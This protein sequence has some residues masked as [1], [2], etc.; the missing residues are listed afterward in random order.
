MRGPLLLAIVVLPLLGV[1]AG[2]EGPSAPRGAPA[3]TSSSSTTP[4]KRATDQTGSDCP[5][6]KAV[7]E[8]RSLRRPPAQTGDVDGDGAVDDVSIALD[9]GGT[10]GCQAFL[11]VEASSTTYV[12]AIVGLDSFASTPD[13]PQIH[14]LVGIDQS[15]G[16]EIVVNVARGAATDIVGV[17]AVDDGR[18]TRVTAPGLA[19]GGSTANLFGYGGSVGHQDA[20]DCAGDAVVVSSAVFR[21]VNSY[22]LTRRFLDPEGSVWRL[23]RSRTKRRVVSPATLPR[24]APEFS[25]SPFLSC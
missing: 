18:L 25:S 4:T 8:D 13:L 22:R 10:V 3:A 11:V 1:I 15:R 19:P 5:D 16:A 9:P 2:C 7:V 6:E 21:G 24:A 12:A 23:Q 17:F 20:T 14:S